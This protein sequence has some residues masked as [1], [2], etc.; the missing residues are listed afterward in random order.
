[1][2]SVAY[3]ADRVNLSP[4]YFGELI[5]KETGLT[6]KE[7]ITN[8]VIAVAKHRLTV[9]NDDISEIAYGLG[10]E[11]PAHFTRLFK[12]VTGQSPTLYRRLM[13]QN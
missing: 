2:P 6:A 1:M 7:I 9:T 13:E 3:F 8:H 5:K 12:R 11:Y 4:G 10:F